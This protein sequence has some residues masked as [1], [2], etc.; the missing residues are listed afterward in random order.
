MEGDSGA[1]K[2]VGDRRLGSAARTSRG[3]KG[4]VAFTAINS[5]DMKH[6]AC[7][8]LTARIVSGAAGRRLP[9][10]LC[11]QND[12]AQGLPPSSTSANR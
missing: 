12:G 4:D 3:S 5:V 11:I 8:L 9:S 2:K 10:P 7:L 1:G 6:S